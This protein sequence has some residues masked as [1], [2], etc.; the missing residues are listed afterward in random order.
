MVEQLTVLG[1]LATCAPG[2]EERCGQDA[3]TGQ[4]AEREGGGVPRAEDSAGDQ[5][6]DGG[7]AK[8]EADLKSSGIAWHGRDCVPSVGGPVPSG[9]AASWI[10]SPAL[11]VQRSAPP[12][13]NAASGAAGIAATEADARLLR[14]EEVGDGDR[15]GAQGAE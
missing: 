7:S 12:R 8:D 9:M 5:A 6:A 14:A 4:D 13:T 10:R 1:R 2:S 11:N 15:L 3:L